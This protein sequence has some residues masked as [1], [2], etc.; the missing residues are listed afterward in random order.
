VSLTDRFIFS[1]PALKVG[2]FR[3][4]CDDPRFRD[5]GPITN[6][7]IVFPRTG[8]WICHEGS[9]PFVADPGIATIYNR[10]QCYTRAPL[11][12]DGDRSDYFA[13]SPELALA[14]AHDVGGTVSDDPDHPFEAE[15]LPIS[16]RLYAMQRHV[17]ELI[18]R[19]ADSLQVEERALAVVAMAFRVAHRRRRSVTGARARAA[20]RDLAMAARA[21]LALRLAEPVDLTTLAAGLGVS[22]WHLCRVFKEQ[23]GTTIHGYRR[24]LRLRTA[25][26]HLDP[27]TGRISMLAH[28]LGFSS[29]SHFTAAFRR[30][31]GFTPSKRRTSASV[32]E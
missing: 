12:A 22:P 1:S 28:Q 18:E 17:V 3:C 19:G 9:R 20:H 2:V 26:E 15:F 11:S 25:L 29:H 23:T 32:G 14:M 31:F 30:R 27:S 13:L 6:H 8:V 21:E 16:P 5:T 7:E 24:D 10:G 4:T